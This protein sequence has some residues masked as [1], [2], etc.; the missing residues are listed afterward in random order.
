MGYHGEGMG[1]AMTWIP[2]SERMPED[3][4]PVL[5]ICHNGRHVEDWVDKDTGDF[6][7]CPSILTEND[8]S[9]RMRRYGSWA[10]HWMELPEPPKETP[11]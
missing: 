4:M 6:L 1:A 5:I 7:N 11:C 10:T 3:D 9:H 2:C 8:A